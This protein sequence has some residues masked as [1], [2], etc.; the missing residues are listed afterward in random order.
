M[1]FRVTADILFFSAYLCE[2]EDHNCPLQELYKKDQ[3]IFSEAAIVR[4]LQKS[5][6]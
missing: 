1:T 2:Y 3:R 5:C 4:V 6:S